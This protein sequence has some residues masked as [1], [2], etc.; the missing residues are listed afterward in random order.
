MVWVHLQ[1]ITDYT[2]YKWYLVMSR[3]VSDLSGS[4][5]FLDS[6]SKF[7]FHIAF[8]ECLSN[9]LLKYTKV[10]LVCWLIDRWSEDAF[11]EPRESQDLALRCWRK[12][13]P[14]LLPSAASPGLFY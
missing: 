14:N 10:F 3:D 4:D 8:Y 6:E 12:V 11:S 2:D 9:H 13:F 1:R 7:S 5:E